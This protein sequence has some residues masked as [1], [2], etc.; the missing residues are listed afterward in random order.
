VLQ[1]APAGDWQARLDFFLTGVKKT[2]DQ[3]TESARRITST[4]T[5]W[6]TSPT[7]RIDSGEGPDQSSLNERERHL[8]RSEETLW[9]TLRI[10]I[11]R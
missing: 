10:T 7:W 5:N 1:D 9:L 6:L 3:A 8:L 2:A 11:R 4:R